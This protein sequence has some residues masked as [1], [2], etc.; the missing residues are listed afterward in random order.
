MCH[1]MC[2][3][4]VKIKKDS[5]LTSFTPEIYPFK[6]V[7]SELGFLCLAMASVTDPVLQLDMNL[8]MTS[9]FQINY[10]GRTNPKVQMWPNEI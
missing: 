9:K 4:E 3:H 7:G 2:V 5:S 8:V 1:R 10:V 6:H